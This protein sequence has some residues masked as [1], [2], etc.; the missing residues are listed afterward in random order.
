MDSATLG[1]E[2][3]NRFETYLLNTHADSTR[4]AREVDH[5]ACRVMYDTFHA[6]IEEKDPIG[7]IGE[8]VAEIGHVHIS[9]ND[10]GAPGKGH[11][12]FDATIAALKAAGEAMEKAGGVRK[13]AAQ[14]LGITFRSFRYRL[15][16]LGLDEPSDG[17]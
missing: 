13:R 16:K 15:E 5:P 3:L 6:N 4:F 10:R 2:C 12:D 1:L 14:L 17:T 7:V 11:I 9:E 8:T